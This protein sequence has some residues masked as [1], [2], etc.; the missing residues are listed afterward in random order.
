MYVADYPIPEITNCVNEGSVTNGMVNKFNPTTFADDGY[1]MDKSK[2]QITNCVSNG[3]LAPNET[4]YVVTAP[5]DAAAVTAEVKATVPGNPAELD[6]VLAE[7]MGLVADDYTTGWEAFEP[8]YAAALADAN[9]ATTQEKLNAHIPLLAEASEGLDLAEIDLAPLTAA[10]EAATA[11]LGDEA[12]YTPLTWGIFVA[13]L[14]NAEAVK[15][16]SDALTSDLKPSDVKTATSKLQT[17]Q[18]ALEELATEEKAELAEVIAKYS[19][20]TKYGTSTYVSTSVDALKAVIAAAQPLVDDVN[21]TKTGVNATI[22]AILDAAEA[23]V[24]KADTAAL[25]AKTT[26]LS[27]TYKLENYTAKTH[28]DL[29]TVIRR[30]NDAISLDDMSQA[31][32]D[33]LIKQLDDAVNKLVKRGNFDAIDAALAPYGDV[34]DEDALEALK[35]NYTS[36]SFKAF[37]DVVAEVSTAKQEDKKPNFSEADAEKLLEKVNSAIAGLVAFATYGDIDAK[38]AEVNALNKDAYTAESWQ[39]L[40]DAIA[41][42]NALKSNRNTT[43]PEADAALAAINATVDALAEVSTDDGADEDKKGCGSAIGATVV[44]MVATLGLGATVVLKKKD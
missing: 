14:E 10:I 17:A 4:K 22:D 39:V 37:S 33:S 32:I 28:N 7:Y 9:K 35:Y 16:E 18:S 5:E 6:A 41:A 24:P 2:V 20:E 43:Q 8:V 26:E 15:E 40:Q 25:K 34:F 13:A 23:L 36:E 29:N 3:A 12:K 11:I 21:A 42:A 19:D 30:A 31:D 1:P 38:I 27:N 44:V